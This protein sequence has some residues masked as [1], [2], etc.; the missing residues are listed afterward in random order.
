VPP[1]LREEW[2]RKDPIARF[3]KKMTALGWASRNEISQLHEEIR[4]E[5]DAAI[6]WAENSPYPDASE[7]LDN[8]YD[9]S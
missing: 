5:V 7:L 3:E 1:G 9:R 6:E 2:E 4:Q 8:V